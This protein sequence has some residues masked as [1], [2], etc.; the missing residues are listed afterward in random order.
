MKDDMPTLFKLDIEDKDEVTAERFLYNL[1]QKN[2][3]E[4]NKV[5][6]E[7]YINS[8][9]TINFAHIKNSYKEYVLKGSWSEE[10]FE[11]VLYIIAKRREMMVPNIFLKYGTRYD[12]GKL[13]KEI[14]LEKRKYE[15][16]KVANNEEQELLDYIAKH[17]G[18]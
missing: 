1:N 18:R 11:E 6:L 15:N 4:I 8:D 5:Y 17:G 9:M 12:D 14:E 2:F 13:T 16:K 7:N 3:I 10:K